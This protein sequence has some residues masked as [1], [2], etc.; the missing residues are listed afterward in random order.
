MLPGC[1]KPIMADCD[2]I[3]MSKSESESACALL[4]SGKIT[5]LGRGSFHDS[6]SRNK[7]RSSLSRM[8]RVVSMQHVC[9]R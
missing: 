3:V 1:V 2:M 6:Y 7:G 5:E 9:V 8:G 4:A